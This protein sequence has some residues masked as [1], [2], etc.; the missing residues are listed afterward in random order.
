MDTLP[1]DLKIEAVQGNLENV[2][3]Q[4]HKNIERAIQRGEQLNDMEE[5]SEQLAN[6]STIFQQKSRYLK[7]KQLWGLVCRWFLVFVILAV[8]LILFL[9]MAGVIH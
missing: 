9:T 2:T 1:V 6:Q 4:M 5:R 3:W 8:V 7:R